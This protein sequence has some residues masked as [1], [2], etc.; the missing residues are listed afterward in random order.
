[1][2]NVLV[3]LGGSSPFFPVEE[4]LYPK[5]LI[6]INGRP[7]IQHVVE[8]LGQLSDD[9]R[10]TF[11]INKDDCETFHLDKVLKLLC[12]DSTQVVVLDGPTMGSVCSCLMAIE[13]IRADE[14]LV[15]VNA[16]QIIDQELKTVVERFQEQKADAGVIVFEAIH[17][18]WSFARIEGGRVIETGEKKPISKHA[19]AGFYYFQQAGT[20]FEAAMLSIKRNSLVDGKFF[21]APVFNELV[22]LNKVCGFV[23]IRS[24]QYHTLYTPQKVTEYEAYLSSLGAR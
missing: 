20:F 5:P 16:D 7:M 4:Y 21:V 23:S 22:L 24:D 12:G 14:P 3:P 13:V 1:M 10:F 8:N 11:V 9:V 2:L 19:I 18:R 15:I 17:P 6:E